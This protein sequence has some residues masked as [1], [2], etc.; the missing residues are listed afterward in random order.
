VSA[1]AP[2]DRGRPR[3]PPGSESTIMSWSTIFLLVLVAV[4][5]LLALTNLKKVQAMVGATKVFYHEVAFEMTKVV[6]PTQSEV[7]NSTIVVLVV[8]VILTLAIMVVDTALSSLVG[9]MFKAPPESGNT[10][11]MLGHLI[12]QIFNA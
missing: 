8:S 5:V 10:I 12:G 1:A 7:I 3:N 4:V 11:A 2:G 9:L 6:W